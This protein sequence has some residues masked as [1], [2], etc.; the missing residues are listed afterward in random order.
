MSLCLSLPRFRNGVRMART[1]VLVVLV[2]STM[3]VKERRG[4]VALT[5]MVVVVVVNSVM[6]VVGGRCL[7]EQASGSKNGHKCASISE[8]HTMRK[9]RVY[10]DFELFVR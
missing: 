6:A 2:L 1:L 9:T 8:T 5:V 10:V 4:S 3:V 7:F